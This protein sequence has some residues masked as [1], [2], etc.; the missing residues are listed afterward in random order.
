MYNALLITAIGMGLVFIAMLALWGL[1][2]L[3][4][5]VTARYVEKEVTEEAVEE[6]ESP[7][8]E[9]VEADAGLARKSRAAVAAVAY[10][11][12][13]A[14]TATGRESMVIA[15]P[16]HPASAWQAV[17]RASQL[18]QQTNLYDRKAGGM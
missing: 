11:L 9:P 16:R 14:E 8:E 4:V 13:Q 15:T 12:A 5:K 17:L 10:A 18:T 1:M 3:S 7:Q 6:S 2:E